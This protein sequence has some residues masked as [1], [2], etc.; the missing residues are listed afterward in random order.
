MQL[1]LT[2]DE[3]ELMKGLTADERWLS[4]DAQA[5]ITRLWAQLDVQGRLRI[6]RDLAE[7]GPSQ[8]AAGVR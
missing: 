7:R 1:N 2:I 3:F 8:L 5:P 6:G 4:G